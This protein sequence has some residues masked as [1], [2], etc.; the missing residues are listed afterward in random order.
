MVDHLVNS[1][2]PYKV[3]M[4]LQHLRIKKILIILEILVINDFDFLK[5]SYK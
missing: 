5:E 3:C 2:N 1:L 4:G